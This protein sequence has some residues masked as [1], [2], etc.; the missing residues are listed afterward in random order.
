MLVS[1]ASNQD[2]AEVLVVATSTVKHHVSNILSKL[3][4]TN[5]TQAIARARALGLL[6]SAPLTEGVLARGRSIRQI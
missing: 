6:S 4:V 5:R 3:D 2:I 1:G